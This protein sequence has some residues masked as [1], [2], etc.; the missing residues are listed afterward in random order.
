MRRE[1]FAPSPTGRLHLGHAFS[2]LTV[3]ENTRRAEGEF[4]LRIEDIDAERC[5]ETHVEAIFHDLAWLGLKWPL[6]VMRQSQ[7]GEFYA[8]ALKKLTD[9]GICYP[10]RCT[11]RDILN[12]QSAPQELPGKKRNA[13]QSLNVYPGTCR[14]RAI[15]QAGPDDAIRLNMAKA[16]EALGG[17]RAV[18]KLSYKDIGAQCGGTYF[19]DPLNLMHGR[20]DIVLARRNIM[21]SYHLSV[22][23]DDSCQ[24]ITHI[25]RGEDLFGETQ[26]HRLLQA[27]LDLKPPVWDHHRLIRDASGRRLAKRSGS[28]AISELRQ[29]GHTP[30]SIRRLVGM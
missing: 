23:V 28:T 13:A 20:G 2:A 24:E 3:W 21:T 11:R 30:G 5:R 27:L 6:P 19:L 17:G 12:S 16:V 7:R 9:L 26:I 22:V 1:R 10:C 25:S 14:T 29:S 15:E 8:N 18:K 4:L